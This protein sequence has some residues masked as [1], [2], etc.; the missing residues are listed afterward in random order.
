M[1]WTAEAASTVSLSAG[2]TV[3][4]IVLIYVVQG[5]MGVGRLGNWTW[6]IVLAFIRE[7]RVTWIFLLRT[8]VFVDRVVLPN[9]MM[10]LKPMLLRLSN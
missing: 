6:N 10:A 3:T 5:C 7:V 9:K 8:T 2:V 4:I 1:P